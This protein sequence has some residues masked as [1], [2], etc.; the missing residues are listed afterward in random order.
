M[1]YSTQRLSRRE[2][3]LL[4]DWERRHQS[5]VLS[6]D[7]AGLVGQ[8]A[9]ARTVSA[10]VRK[11]VLDRVGRGIYTVR[12]F[13]AVASPWTTSSLAVVAQLLLDEPY[14][15]CGLA[16]LS[17]HRLTHQ[18]YGS[19]LDVAIT[20]RRRSRLLGN[21]RVVFHTLPAS[22]FAYGLEPVQIE[23]TTVTVSDP[24]RTLLDLLAHPALA[25]GTRQALRTVD[26]A[27]GQVDQARL[28]DYALRGA[29]SSVRQRL[30]LLLERAQAPE[31]VLTPLLEQVWR[32]ASVPA[33]LPDEP[34]VGGL[35][36]RWRIVLNDQLVS[37]DGPQ[38]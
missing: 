7:I 8:S 10:L 36:P 17:L 30:G 15:V 2:V 27:L 3:A 29:R 16:A 14:Y 20:G 35:H 19:L 1:S 38:S 9:A 6:R 23:A 33:M 24:E 18:V 34:R 28:V 4:T 13:R 37:G 21:A 26:K 12:P 31:A 22:D 25:G 5:R 32:S 11:G